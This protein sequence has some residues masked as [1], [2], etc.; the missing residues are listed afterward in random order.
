MRSMFEGSTPSKQSPQPLQISVN[1]MWRILKGSTPFQELPRPLQT[2]GKNLA[3]NPGRL[4][5]LQRFTAAPAKGC[6][7][8]AVN[9]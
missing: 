7:L 3:V 1:L 9:H 5:S 6:T 8:H 4:Y 2:S